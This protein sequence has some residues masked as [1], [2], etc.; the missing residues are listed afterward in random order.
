[1]VPLICYQDKRFSNGSAEIIDKANDILAEYERQ[2]YELTLRGLY[3]KFVGRNLIANKLSEYKR[4]G[5][6]INDARLAGL[7][8]WLHIDDTIRSVKGLFHWEN[9]RHILDSC[10]P[11]YKSNR[12]ET[13][14]THVEVWV[15]KDAVV[16]VISPI[17]REL[18][19]PYFACRGYA[20]Q[21]SL[22]RAGQR[23]ECKADEGKDVLIVHLGD[24][25]PSGIDMTRDNQDR[26]DIFAGL[27]NVTVKRIALNMDQIEEYDPPPNPAKLTDSRAGD[28]ILR[29]GH[30][31]WELDAL[32]PNIIS[33]LIRAEVE[34]HIDWDLW[35]ETI[36]RDDVLKEKLREFVAGWTE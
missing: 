25:D 29:F 27:E 18:D 31:S 19:V 1:M 14:D 15:E 13:Q 35:N 36:E 22:W 10:A 33:D 6:I 2:G 12:W 9:G 3:Y 17:C 34:Q 16:G 4:F 21:S 24:H 20:S 32:D 7:I 23:L 8:D 30:E 11:S 26:L 5:S 28:Y